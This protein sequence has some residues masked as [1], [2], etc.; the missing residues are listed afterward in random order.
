MLAVNRLHILGSAELRNSAG[1]LEHSFLAGSKRLGLLV[2]L[3][4]R[5][6]QGLQRRDHLLALFWPDLGQQSARNALSN[7]LH[8]IR[9][10]L[11]SDVLVSRGAEEIGINADLLWCDAPAFEAA[12]GENQLHDAV[13]LYR[14]PLLDGFH[15]AGAAPAFDHWLDRERDRLRRSYRDTL[16][17]L[18]EAAET[19][20][21]FAVAAQH[22][23]ALAD[24]DPYD[25]ESARR[26]VRALAAA[27]DRSAAQRTALTRARLI[28]EG[29]DS[30]PDEELNL[31]LESISTVSA[32]PAVNGGAVSR[33]S[34]ATD[35]AHPI[36]HG[37]AVLPFETL[38][39][40]PSAGVSEGIHG[41]LLTRLSSVAALRV[42]SRTSVRRYR[43]TDKSISQIGREL[44]VPWILEGEVQ[45]ASDRVRVNVR[46]VDART[47]QPVW[48]EDY[49]R[50][51]TVGDLFEI[52][53]EITKEIAQSLEVV[54]APEEVARLE[55]QPTTNLEAY[56]LCVQGRTHLDLRTGEGMRRALGYFERAVEIDG[57]N[58]L[59]W[60]GVADALGLLLDYGYEEAAAVLPRV[61]EAVHR[62]LALDPLSAEAHASLGGL[63]G[64]RRQ[65]PAARNA[66]LRAVE[67]RPNYAEAHNWLSWLGNLLGYRREALDSAR[68]AVRLNPLS[69]EAVSNLALSYLT[70]GELDRALAEARRDH[71]LGSDWS[72]GRLYEGQTLYEMGHF[73]EAASVLRGLEEPW[74]GSG[75]RLTLALASIASGASDE[76]RTLL[77]GFESEDDAFA[78]G[79]VHAA[80][81]DGE[82]ATAA[83]NRVTWGEHWP[84]L[85]VRHFYR[86][87]WDTLQNGPNR[88]ALLR[89]VDRSWGL[90]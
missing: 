83:L 25:A 43:A 35:N 24:D 36:A 55:R 59:A 30:D 26:L 88:E 5:R 70:N 87:V 9:R 80:L 68:R 56:R 74:A 82:T 23:Q 15:L 77:A 31:L 40:E 7:M 53:S 90:V 39:A 13:R 38:G 37:L 76:A 73:G 46:L 11:G 20:A 78:A 51:L 49:L 86:D 64:H 16:E 17:A 1:R 28:A 32:S 81:G 22:W 18:A 67:L 6:T 34:D 10:A 84:T 44:N 42:I 75:P 14:G 89:K 27:G 50:A 71:E 45:E 47:D 2:Y 58:V 54:L 12:L 4:L 57:T 52:Q 69:P 48:A 19:D 85:A 33:P 3:T 79:L 21:A 72:T 8:H 61:D 29:L 66:L 60:V 63:L 65:G 41:D 62:A